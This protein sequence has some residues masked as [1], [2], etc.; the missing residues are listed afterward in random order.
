MN[1]IESFFLD[2]NFSWTLS[3]ISPL[4]MII[5]F[6][7]FIF[8]ILKKLFPFKIRLFIGVFIFITLTTCYFYVFPVYKG[9]LYD[10]GDQPKTKIKLP[11]NK[12]LIV[13]A[14]PGCP[15]CHE[16]VKY[17]QRLIERNSNIELEIWIT[18]EQKDLFYNSI[19]S[20]RVKIKANIDSD[21][22]FYITNGVFP[23][24]AITKNGKLEKRWSNQ[25]F[26]TRALDEIESF[27]EVHK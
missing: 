10:L 4:L 25:S 27:F 8:W 26:G 18:G 14:L 23:T 1:R 15:Y 19:I 6:S 24:F 21:E 13:F 16:S 2:L 7:I 20:D 17:L 11:I 9:D 22:T 3:K 5:V 12:R